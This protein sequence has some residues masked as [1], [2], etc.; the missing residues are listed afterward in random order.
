MRKLIGLG[1]ACF[2]MAFPAHAGGGLTGALIGASI[3]AAVGHAN[4]PTGGAA[5]GALVGA[6]GGYV[7]GSAIAEERREHR[8]EERAERRHEARE[9]YRSHRA[10]G[11][12]RIPWV[13]RMRA[14]CREGQEF[15]DRAFEVRKIEKQVYYLEKAAWYCP[16]D[17]R[18]HNDLGVAYFFRDHGMDRQRAEDQFRIALYLRPDYQAPKDNLRRMHR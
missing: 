1:I 10:K 17:A 18:A 9:A 11:G 13:R 14:R 4:D 8:Q 6:A 2:A 7:L 16:W 3:G 15:Y 12:V 5:R